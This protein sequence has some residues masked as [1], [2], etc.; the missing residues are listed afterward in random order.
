M[1]E[2]NQMHGSCHASWCVLGRKQFSCNLKIAKENHSEYF[3]D[4]YEFSRFV[5]LPVVSVYVDVVA[6]YVGGG[7]E[8]GC[9]VGMHV[10]ACGNIVFGE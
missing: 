10:T 9:T 1:N 6:V 2:A 7:N 3:T 5:Y 4:H 8:G